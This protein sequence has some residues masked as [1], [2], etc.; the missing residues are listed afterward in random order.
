MLGNAARLSR[1]QDW[2]DIRADIR[3]GDAE[4]GLA[5]VIEDEGDGLPPGIDL[6]IDL[7]APAEHPASRGVGLGLALARTLM[8]AHGGALTVQSTSQVGSRVVLT[9]PADCLVAGRQFA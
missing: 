4:D 1:D 8:Q 2:I 7:G 5:I 9:F 6:G 3:A